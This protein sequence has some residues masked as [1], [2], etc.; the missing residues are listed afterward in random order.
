MIPLS[1]ISMLFTHAPANTELVTMA[2]I[3][4]ALRVFVFVCFGPIKTPDLQI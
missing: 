3:T 2:A 4:P 1:D